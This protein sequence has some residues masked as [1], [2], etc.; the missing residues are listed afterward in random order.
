MRVIMRVCLLKVYHNPV[1]SGYRGLVSLYAT[2]GS[3]QHTNMCLLCDR[4]VHGNFAMHGHLVNSLLSGQ[5]VA[6]DMNP[7]PHLCCCRCGFHRLSQAR[8]RPTD[9]RLERTRGNTKLCSQSKKDNFFF[10]P[11]K[12]KTL[13]TALLQQSV[14]QEQWEMGCL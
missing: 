8:S 4:T 5:E 7:T 6:P 12:T 3:L 13:V 1:W 14:S 10:P 9:M 11:E 2:E